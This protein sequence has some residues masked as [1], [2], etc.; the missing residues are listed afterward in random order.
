MK[1]L[2]LL[3]VSIVMIFT[4]AS[5]GD[6]EIVGYHIDENGKLIA[7]YEDDTTVDLGT[8]TDTIAN[9]ANIITVNND[10]YYVIN[11]VVSKIEA[12]LPESY[13]IDIEG[14][15]I[16]TYTDTTTENLGKFGNDAINTIDTISISDD[17]FYVLNGIKT[18]II[19]VDVFEVKFVTGYDA[20]AK[21]QI[22]KDG[23]KI[24]RPQLERAGYTLK[25]WYCNGEEWRFNSDVVLN[26]MTLT[27]EWIA[28]DYAVSFNTGTSETLPNQTI[29]FD[30]EYA[31]PTLERTGYTFKG[32]EHNG[33]L[34]TASKWNI[35]ENATLV[36]KWEVNKYTITLDANG[37]IVSQTNISVLYGE[38]F[39]LPVPTN[40]F[41]TF[42][43]WYYNDTKITD[44]NGKS[45]N[46]WEY[47]NDITV[48]TSWVTEIYTVSDLINIRNALGG[49]YVLMADIDISSVDW[50]PLGASSPGLGGLPFNSFTGVFDGNNHTISGLRMTNFMES[51]GSYGFVGYNFGTIKNLKLTNI[52]ISFTGITIDVYVGGICGYN[53]GTIDNCVVEGSISVSNHSGSYDSKVGGIAGATVSLTINNEV[54]NPSITNCTNNAS[55]TG[56]TYVGGIAGFSMDNTTAYQ[57]CINNGTIYSPNIAGGIV[58]YSHGDTFIQC[59]NTG[60]IKGN[61]EAGGILGATVQN[62]LFSSISTFNQCVNTAKVQT[63]NTADCEAGGIAGDVY[64]A[65]ITNCYNTGD[66]VGH[67]V[68]GILGHSYWTE[69]TIS[70]TYNNG[71]IVGYQYAA[72][73]LGWGTQV[74]IKDSIN[75]GT[76]SSSSVKGYI[77]GFNYGGIHANCYYKSSSGTFQDAEAAGVS[78]T[79]KAIN[80][81]TLY[82]SVVYWSV[83]DI[84][85]NDG[86]WIVDGINAPALLWENDN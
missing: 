39:K 67:R 1:K 41:G 51:M 57:D 12:K 78:S 47:L 70:N 69:T 81:I 7:T 66:I 20:T 32:W 16:V 36:A 40:D 83:V 17:G 52:S 27:A 71:K 35:A 31:L 29:T 33:K 77:S 64:C 48:S 84:L 8:L 44:E 23:D 82:T 72:G 13:S 24:E 86:I 19:A 75:F 14:N 61:K 58:G 63:S 37:G 3:L 42:K 26:E 5:C 65:I 21:T 4:L 45:L 74:E 34:V 2:L 10:G 85:E 60:A 50:I 54:Y 62:S 22:I 46:V 15:L 30:S 43:G 56:N 28:N 79:S 38:D 68:G 59:K 80:D 25:G 6:P 49:H 9:G 76:I 73:I 18:S 55:V 53:R 11:G